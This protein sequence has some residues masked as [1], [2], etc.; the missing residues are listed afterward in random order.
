MPTGYRYVHHDT[1]IEDRVAVNRKKFL[2]HLVDTKM[3]T[4]HRHTHQ[5]AYTEQENK[6][7]GNKEKVLT[8]FLNPAGLLPL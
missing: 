3:P 1:Y 5:D 4:V 2:L 7:S 6:S 8:V